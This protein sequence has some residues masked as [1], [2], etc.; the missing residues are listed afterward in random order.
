MAGK[1]VAGG[2]FEARPLPRGKNIALGKISADLSKLAAPA[3]YRLVVE[4]HAGAAF[5]NEWK[6]WVYPAEAEASVPEGLLVTS[7]WP[8]AE[9]KL[10]AGGR[11]LF[12]PAA[13]SL[14]ANSPKVSTVP[15]FWNHL[16]NPN[17]TTFMGLYVDH[18]HPA[19]A[20]FP[21]EAN[22]DWQWV[23]LFNDT[24][25]LDLTAFPAE[26]QPI[27]QSIDD[28]NRSLK[29]ALLYECAVGAGRLMVCSL[30]VGEQS[31]RPGTASLRRSILSYMD[32]ARFA[33]GAVVAAEVL[34]AQYQNPHAAPAA[35]AQ[36]KEP[37]SPDLV[38]PGQIRRKPGGA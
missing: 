22:C 14:D 34:R 16:M 7:S 35:P 19:L 30:D 8:E 10:A 38:D 13:S 4:L 37:S 1:V 29:L 26:F 36:P 28:W 3:Q 31:G 32:S 25:A 5:R 18:K 23:D 11:V 33:P 12:L 15:I 17:G 2:K 9:A 27:V 21:T 24:H 20:G 6:F